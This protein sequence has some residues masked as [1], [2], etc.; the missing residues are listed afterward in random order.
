MAELALN[1]WQKR[2]MAAFPDVSAEKRLGAL[3]D[4]MVRSRD[5]PMRWRQAIDSSLAL[6]MLPSSF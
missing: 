3:D 6:P 4:D 1:K 5:V 2:E